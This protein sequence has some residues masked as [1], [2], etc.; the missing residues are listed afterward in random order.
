[1]TVFQALKAYLSPPAVFAILNDSVHRE[2]G[3]DFSQL[4]VGP[5][6]LLPLLS[7]E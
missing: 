5:R 4:Y 3:W 2:H 1:V 7:G 6:G